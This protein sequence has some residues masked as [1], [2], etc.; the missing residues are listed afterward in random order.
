MIFERCSSIDLCSGAPSPGLLRATVQGDLCKVCLSL[1]CTSPTGLSCCLLKLKPGCHPVGTK[2]QRLRSSGGTAR[3]KEHHSQPPVIT[4]AS[5]HHRERRMHSLAGARHPSSSLRRTWSTASGLGL[6][7]LKMRTRPSQPADA[8]IL[9]SCLTAIS[10]T[11]FCFRGS[12]ACSLRC[13]ASAVTC[14][15]HSWSSAAPLKAPAWPLTDIG[16]PAHSTQLV[17]AQLLVSMTA[18]EAR[19]THDHGNSATA[20]HCLMAA[21]PVP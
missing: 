11:P 21:V 7:H 2:P 3:Q 14:Q 9:P 13:G 20:H 19:A 17:S 18:P 5:K 8:S 10:A 4:A 15:Q 16:H 6:V 12:F 1:C